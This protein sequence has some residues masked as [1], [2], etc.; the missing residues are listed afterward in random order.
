MYRYRHKRTGTVLETPCPCA[1]EDW[2]ALG[3]DCCDL[4]TAAK[5]DAGAKEARDAPRKPQ[6]PRTAKE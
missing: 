2:E 5:N 1:G 6:K 4:N 3:G